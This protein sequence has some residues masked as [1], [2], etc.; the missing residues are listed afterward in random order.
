MMLPRPIRNQNP[1]D[2]GAAGYGRVGVG[3]VLA[4][5]LAACTTVQ[6]SQLPPDALRSGIR[7]GTLVEPGDRV[8]VVTA[9]GREYA[10]TVNAVDTEMIRGE[11]SEGTLV[12]IAIDDVIALR[13]REVEPV[14]TTFAALYGALAL[15][16]VVLT[17]EIFDTW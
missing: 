9:G 14:R 1:G 10:F 4:V 5:L 2:P 15:A 13:K 8:S 16:L 11:S 12:G 3:L 6:S 17:V 7:S